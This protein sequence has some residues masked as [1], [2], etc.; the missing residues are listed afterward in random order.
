[1]LYICPSRG[2]PDNVARLIQAWAETRTIASLFIALDDDDPELSDYSETLITYQEEHPEATWLDWEVRPRMRL[3]GTLNYWAVEKSA[4]YSVVGFLGDDHV[5]RTHGFD[6]Q[7]KYAMDSMG[8]TGVV[9]GNDLLQGA[10][11]PTAVAISSDIVRTLGYYVPPG[12]THLYLDNYWKYLGER[13]GCLRYLSD[14]I[15]EHMHPAGG[16]AE[17]DD[18]YVE[19]NSGEMYTEDSRLFEE[20]KRIKSASDIALVI[21]E[22]AK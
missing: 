6:T 8:G 5:P 11:L 3:G 10:N 15:I 4:A 22:T 20:W 18:R 2:R 12:M 13:L 21:L 16:K 17:W 7:I 1:M 19:V 9:Y 14:V